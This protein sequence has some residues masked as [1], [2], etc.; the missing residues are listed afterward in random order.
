[1][2]CQPKINTK[3]IKKYL[4]SLEFCIKAKVVSELALVQNS[5]EQG[6]QAC[7]RRN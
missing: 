4:K 3:T 6:A 7:Q 1:M 5:V 2:S